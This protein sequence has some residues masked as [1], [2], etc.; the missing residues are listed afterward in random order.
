MYSTSLAQPSIELVPSCENDPRLQVKRGNERQKDRGSKERRK[1]AHSHNWFFSEVE[2]PSNANSTHILQHHLNLYH[3]RWEDHKT[4]SWQ[5][6]QV[7]IKYLRSYLLWIMISS[8]NLTRNTAECEAGCWKFPSDFQTNA[9]T[10]LTTFVVPF[11]ARRYSVP[12][13]W[14]RVYTEQ[15]VMKWG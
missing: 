9:D 1:E 3:A 15:Y 6:A 14:S 11:P 4:T 13:M 8:E 7:F 12:K 10:G 5:I 2:Q